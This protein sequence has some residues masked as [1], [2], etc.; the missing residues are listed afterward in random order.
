[1]PE[2]VKEAFRRLHTTYIVSQDT[3]V[4]TSQ[5]HRTQPENER[6]CLHKLQECVDDACLSA[7]GLP[8]RGERKQSRI[9]KSK[10]KLR[11]RALKKVREAAEV[12]SKGQGKDL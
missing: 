12:E 3:F 2:E 1:M 11:S 6:S 10:A 5:K 9:Q 4:V 8:T 7:A